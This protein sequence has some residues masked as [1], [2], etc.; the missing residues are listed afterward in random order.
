M[1][2]TIEA[3]DAPG[4]AGPSATRALL[5]RSDRKGLARLAI[6]LG[7]IALSSTGI[8][9]A[10]GS[11]L[12]VPAMIVQGILIAYLFSPLHEG[13]HCTPF[14]S[15]RL[16]EIVAWLSGVAIIWNA[17]YMRYSHLWHH[18]YIQ[19]PTRDPELAS[20]KPT[21]IRTYLRRLSGIDYLRGN[22]RDQ[23]R[24]VGGRFESMPY[25]PAAARPA[26]RR[27]VLLQLVVYT[28]AAACFPG[29][30]LLYWLVPLLLGY[31][32]LLIV[33]MAEH[34]G[35]AETGDN[36]VNTRTTYTWWPLRLIFWNMNYHAEHHVNPA[37]PFHALPAAHQLMKSRVT[38]I[39]SGGYVAWT[40]HYIRKLSAR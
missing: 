31:P 26:A 35:C 9:V 36:Y 40:G 24:I 18:R 15:R 5:E 1:D 30:L 29:P 34:A 7:L 37:I 3:M 19:D 20:P 32:F 39:S 16:N 6:H 17:A 27:S 21:S 8:Y 23:L 4:T 28:V 14:K 22:I 10:R 12:L 11:L 33:L 13:V 38:H 25:I 2:A